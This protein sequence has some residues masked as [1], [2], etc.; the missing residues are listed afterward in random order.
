MSDEPVK[1]S[2]TGLVKDKGALGGVL[3]SFRLFFKE[4]FIL[5][6][7]DPEGEDRVKSD[8]GSRM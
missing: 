4:E 6:L 5:L 2:L 7:F 8:L 3:G 1:G